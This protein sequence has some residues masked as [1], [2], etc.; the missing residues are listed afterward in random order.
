MA[1]VFEDVFRDLIVAANLT[2]TRVFI[3]QSPQVPAEQA[4]T[5]YM[6]ITP[7]GPTP[8]HTHGGP[9]GLLQ[10]N[11]QVAIFD[12]RQ[13]IA[14]AIADSLR[15]YLDGFTGEFGGVEFGGIFFSL[16]SVSFEADTLLFEALVQFRVWFRE[17]SSM[18]RQRR[19]TAVRTAVTTAVTNRSK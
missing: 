2:D 16:Q 3:M 9:V 19:K 8:D 10:R 5:P 13:S 17:T 15:H 12:P 14:L 6:V 7:T 11:Y 18:H 1:L 4:R